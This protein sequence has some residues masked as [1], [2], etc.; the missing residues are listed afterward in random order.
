MWLNI[1]AGN[2]I[3]PNPF[4]VYRQLVVAGGERGIFFSIGATGEKPMF[5]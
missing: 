3:G 2:G 5:L 4:M 1:Y